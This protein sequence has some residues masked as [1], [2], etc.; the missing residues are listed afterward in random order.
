[1]EWI[2]S[3]SLALLRVLRV[4]CWLVLVRFVFA[5]GAEAKI[6]MLAKSWYPVRQM[7]PHEKRETNQNERRQKAETPESSF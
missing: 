4:A 7:L 6:K 5:G 1:M 3:I 2:C